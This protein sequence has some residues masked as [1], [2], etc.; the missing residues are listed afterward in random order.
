MQY[1][2]PN[3]RGAHQVNGV[4]HVGKLVCP[5]SIWRQ[6][7][8]LLHTDALSMISDSLFG[9]ADDFHA[10]GA[11]LLHAGERAFALSDGEGLGAV[12]PREG[13]G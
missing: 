3:R 13:D 10:E 1:A 9:A 4:P 5:T 12:V 7:R 6:W 8:V 2:P 11:R